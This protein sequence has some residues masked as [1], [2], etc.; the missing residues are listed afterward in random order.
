MALG[1]SNL[2]R[3][4]RRARRA[5]AVLSCTGGLLLWSLHTDAGATDFVETTE[6]PALERCGAAS[7]LEEGPRYRMCVRDTPAAT[8][9]GRFVVDGPGKS[10][11]TGFWREGVP[12][13][14]WAWYG[15]SGKLR[16]ESPPPTA[17]ATECGARDVP[18]WSDLASESLSS[19]RAKLEHE[20]AP[21]LT[22][23]DGH[24]IPSG[25][26]GRVYPIRTFFKRRSMPV[27]GLGLA[28]GKTTLWSREGMIEAEFS[29]DAQ[30][31][32]SGSFT[33]LFPNGRRAR[34]A[35][36]REGRLHGQESTWWK[37]G[38]RRSEVGW[39]DGR[40][41]GDVQC[42]RDDKV[43]RAV[44]SFDL[45]TPCGVFFIH[46]FTAVEP[47]SACGKLGPEA[48]DKRYATVERIEG[49]PDPSVNVPPLR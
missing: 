13:G 17:V 31:L 12:F 20:A 49:L 35:A 40:L 48:E 41:H 19:L 32:L 6:V 27:R 22:M 11:L 30:G 45:G 10:A 38:E 8:P 39:K 16:V 5:A 3:R 47:L 29:H 4:S 15:R 2:L 43:Q 18:C 1:A 7:V 9:H 46:G 14:Q 33:W 34:D 24:S 26:G 37:N 25:R 28:E 44:G 42:W 21:A 23:G 36:F